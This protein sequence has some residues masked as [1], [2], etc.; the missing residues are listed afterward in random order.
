M[1]PTNPVA[2]IHMMLINSK[3]NAGRQGLLRGHAYNN[4][5]DQSLLQ[6]PNKLLVEFPVINSKTSVSVCNIKKQKKLGSGVFLMFALRP[7]GWFLL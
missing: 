3:A 5:S 4:Q 7:G 1:W 6:Q 2:R